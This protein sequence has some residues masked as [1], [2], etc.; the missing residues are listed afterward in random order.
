MR[1]KMKWVIEASEKQRKRKYGVLLL[2]HL[3]L[4]AAGYREWKH[5]A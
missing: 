3:V 4:G 1:M 2:D 5:G